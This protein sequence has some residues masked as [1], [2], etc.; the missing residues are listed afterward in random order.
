ME[1]IAVIMGAPDI[2]SRSADATTLLNYGF[3]KCRIYCD[4]HEDKL[5]DL[6]VKKALRIL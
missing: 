3:G 1:L 6:P 4:N 2:K 5:D